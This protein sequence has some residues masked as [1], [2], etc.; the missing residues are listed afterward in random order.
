MT[1]PNEVTST[2]GGWRIL[3]VFVALRGIQPGWLDPGD[4]R[5]REWTTGC[6]AAGRGGSVSYRP[7]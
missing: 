4:R 1:M 5:V 3:L 2:D 7:A 6:S